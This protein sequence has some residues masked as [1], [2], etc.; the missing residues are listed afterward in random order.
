MSAFYD[1]SVILR[2]SFDELDGFA[3]STFQTKKLFE[4]EKNMYI[5]CSN[6]LARFVQK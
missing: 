6:Y 2:R 4:Y 3:I 5:D 1:P